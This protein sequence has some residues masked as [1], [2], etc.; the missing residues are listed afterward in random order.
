MI[1][2]VERC[3]NKAEKIP[4]IYN[5]KL[6]HSD[7][8]T[9]K[10]YLMYLRVAKFQEA[11]TWTQNDALMTDY[12]V[13]PQ[14]SLFVS[15]P[16]PLHSNLVSFQVI[17]TERERRGILQLLFQSAFLHVLPSGPR[18]SFWPHTGYSWPPSQQGH[19]ADIR[20]QLARLLSLFA[21]PH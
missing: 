5:N 21:K 17:L 6:F 1:W 19:T 10:E 20:T 15:N 18:A 4:K 8:R 12:L 11:S 3:W 7:R 13:F 9:H 14:V 16:L 2:I